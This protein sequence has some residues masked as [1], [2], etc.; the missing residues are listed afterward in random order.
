MAAEYQTQH[1][2]RLLAIAGALLLTLC[3]CFGGNSAQGNWGTMVASLLAVP[4][5]ILAAFRGGLSAQTP[6]VRWGRIVAVAIL[7]V[8]ALQLLPLPAFLWGLPSARPSLLQD[9]EA[10]GVLG[11]DRRWSLMPA[12]TE[13]EIWFLL[14]GIALFF[15]VQVIGRRGW[16]PMLWLLIF[17]TLANL[18]FAVVQIKA[19]RDS[20]L[21]LYPA[22]APQWGGVFANSNHQADMLAL[23]LML[24]LVLFGRAWRRARESGHYGAEVGTL[25]GLALIFAIALPIVGSRAGVIIVMLMLL[26]LLASSGLAKF[27]VL[28][29]SRVRLAGVVLAMVV[30]IIGLNAAVGWLRI[31]AD[32]TST[33]DSRARM[34]SETLKVGVDHA[35]WGAGVGSFIPAYQQGAR[36]DGLMNVYVN[37][38]HNDYAQ[39]WLEAG[40]LGVAVA[41]LALG[42]LVG[43]LVRLLRLPLESGTRTSGLAAMMGIGVIVLHSMVDYPLRT[44]ALMAVFAVLSGIAVAAA[45][46]S[47]ESARRRKRPGRDRRLAAEIRDVD[48]TLG[49]FRR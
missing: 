1:E 2:E 40:I 5:L 13:R 12:A 38:A 47:P 49:D 21:N 42:V 34:S 6:L 11:L 35:P 17:L 26:A 45:S 29:E 37:N 3:F 23:A 7:L 36:N 22:Y 32:A 20:P 25:A 19:G 16:R 31:D 44:Q 18:V 33:A 4:V 30:L 27:R 48:G 24:V 28:R 10:V 39:W 9:L 15:C 14:P 43:A 41:L 46:A 8:P